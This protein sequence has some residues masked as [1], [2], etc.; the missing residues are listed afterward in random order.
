MGCSELWPGPES[1]EVWDAPGR[2]THNNNNIKH[3][4]AADSH[5]QTNTVTVLMS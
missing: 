4:P 1:E 5:T 2:L 3:N